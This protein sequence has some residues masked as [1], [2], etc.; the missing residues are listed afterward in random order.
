MFDPISVR[1]SPGSVGSSVGRNDFHSEQHLVATLDAAHATVCRG[2]RE[3]LAL[4][5]EVDR[6]D[7]WHGSGARD[8]AHWV[9]M[10]YGISCWKAN[11][12][13]AAAHALE[14]LPRLSDAL[15]SGE[16]GLDKVVELTRFAS[17]G[18][19]AGLISW[20]KG[21]SC[22][23]VRHRADL[24][25]RASIE[26]DLDAERSRFVSWWYFD[27]GRRLGLEAELPAAQGAIVVRAL[28][29]AAEAIPAM[30]DERDGSFASARRADALVALCSA[31]IARDTDQDRATVVIHAQLDGVEGGVGGCEI[32]GGTVVHPQTVRRLLCNAR[33]QSVLED[34]AG[35]VLG[36]GRTSREPSTWMLRQ[37]RYRDR[38]CRFPGC[39]ARRFTQAHHIVWWRHG[40]R[41]DLDN[42]LLICSFH[43]RLVHEHGWSVKRDPDGTVR[44]FLPGG[45]RYRAGPSPGA[46]AD[47]EVVLTAA[48]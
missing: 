34:R 24:A 15:A 10:R 29:R 13:I 11:R 28:E 3:L 5:A 27:E 1:S 4:I 25:R 41:T 38:E 6:R 36:L 47:H 22:A 39:G 2:Q 18:T 9:S 45:A 12:W 48:G 35:N 19:E 33:V 32:D 30:P 16:L 20:A 14:G 43:H 7:S 37:V 26:A 44:W 17:P 40:G 23:T 31:R 8:T 21:V 46:D 42:L